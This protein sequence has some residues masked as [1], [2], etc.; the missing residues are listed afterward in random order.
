MMS[1]WMKRSAICLCAAVMGFSPVVMA[2]ESPEQWYRDGKQFAKDAARMTINRRPAKNVI[3]FLGDGMGVT[4]VTAARILDGQMKGMMGEENM[5]SF[6]EMPYVALSKV[7]ETNQ[8]APDS[9]GTMSA[10]MTGVKTDAGVIAMNQNVVRGDYTTH[11]GNEAVTLLEKCEQAGMSTGVV[12]STRI[13]HATPAACYAHSVER[14]WECDD[15][16]PADAAAAG[17][18]DIARQLI[19][20]PIGNGIE[21]AMGGGRRYFIPNT[22]AD[23]EDAGKTGQRADGRDLTAEWLAQYSNSA[24][25]WNQAQFDAIDTESTDHLLGLFERS[26]CEYEYDRPGDTAGE[27]SLSEMT[28]KAI[29]VLDNNR[30]GFFLMVEGGRID[31]AHHANNAYR[32]L[33]DTI[34]FAEAVQVAMDLTNSRDTLIIVTADHGHVMAFGGY[35]TRGNP[36]LGKVIENDS[37]GNPKPDYQLDMLGL[38]YT[39]LGYTNGPGYTGASNAQPEGY[40]TWEHY[41][42]SYSG[43]TMGRPDLTNVDTAMPSFLQEA[44]VPLSS[45][46]HSGEDVAFYA[47]GPGAYMVHGTME[48]NYIFHVMARALRLDRPYRC[49]L[50]RLP[51][52]WEDPD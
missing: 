10:I 35:A 38:P 21:V 22:M 26:H 27:P 17:Y 11:E 34:E 46:T 45:D 1:Q 39:T 25:A 16:L 33:T 32:T 31:H 36:I 3:V 8:Q 13:T 14:N 6:D 43:I 24:Y 23:P 37:S 30:K 42:S 47:D 28:A 48:Q 40:K 44:T 51:M 20:F 5:L 29:Q 4:T 9:A 2:E 18:K 50:G 41:P 49:V 15:Q 19:E 12:S 52:I 7:Y